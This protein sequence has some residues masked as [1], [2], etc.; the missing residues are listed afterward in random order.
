M[1][2]E[3][4]LIIIF[5]LLTMGVVVTTIVFVSKI[6]T[7]KNAEKS[8]LK[9]SDYP[10]NNISY[11]K[12]FEQSDYIYYVVIYKNDCPACEELEPIVCEYIDNYGKSNIYKV[13]LLNCETCKDS[14]VEF[15]ENGNVV[16]NL[17]VSKNGDENGN[18]KLKDLRISS[19]PTML[20][21]QDSKVV[22]AQIGAKLIKEQLN[23]R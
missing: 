5:G 20:M 4:V 13:Y 14:I 2:K 17:Y 7:N 11:N 6:F 10:Q 8:E 12:I 18:N 19:T 23:S 15:D 3:N 9:Y 21:I 22:S 1:K 16:T